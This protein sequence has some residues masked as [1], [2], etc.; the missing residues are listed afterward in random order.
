MATPP[1]VVD[2]DLWIY[3]S[4]TPHSHH[5][6]PVP[7]DRGIG[8]RALKKDRWV[9][10]RSADAEAELLT[11]PIKPGKRLWLNASTEREGWIRVAVCDDWG[12]VYK[13]YGHEVCQAISGDSLRHEVH[14]SGNTRLPAPEKEMRL[15][16]YSRKA[17]I[18]GFTL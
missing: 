7:E 4:G 14:W 3:Y 16:I 15:R 2:D 13:G 18:Y 12:R 9:R 11:H 17:S 10:Y 1:V 6:E 5:E 8:V